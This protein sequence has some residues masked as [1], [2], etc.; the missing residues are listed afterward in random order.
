[1]F[2]QYGRK[3]RMKKILTILLLISAA[4]YTLLVILDNIGNSSK[5]IAKI[6][7]TRVTEEQIKDKFLQLFNN[8]VDNKKFNIKELPKEAITS[9]SK[10]IYLEQK[11]L[12]QAKKS[13]IHRE[14]KIQNRIKKSEN[15]IIIESYLD[16]LIKENTTDEKINNKYLEITTKL[17]GKKEYNISKIIL[18]DKELADKIYDKL[19]KLNPRYLN[20][21]FKLLY[22]QHSINKSPSDREQTLIE[23]YIPSDILNS[24]DNGEMVVKKEMGEEVHIYKYNSSKTI[25]ISQLDDQYKEE[26]KNILTKEIMQNFIKKNLENKKVKI[27]D[28]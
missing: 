21:Q 27:M 18:K 25:K 11:L 28:Y 24:F 23:T 13:G 15:S 26:I 20:Y 4:S 19:S 5:T 2:K 12:E 14:S 3:K 8:S 10:E 16:K 17:D 6:G 9:L 1:M 7:S 22:N